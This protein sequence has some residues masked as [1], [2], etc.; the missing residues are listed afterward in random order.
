[1]GFTWSAD[2]VGEERFRHRKLHFFSFCLLDMIIIMPKKMLVCHNPI[3]PKKSAE[4]TTFF[5]NQRNFFFVPLTDQI[6]I[7]FI[8]I[9][10]IDVKHQ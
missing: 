2:M 9:F 5:Q 10:A 3:N 6:M 7:C 4:P 1:M 8:A